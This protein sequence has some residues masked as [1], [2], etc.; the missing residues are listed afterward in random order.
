MAKSNT[1]PIPKLELNSKGIF[2][3]KD[4][5][6]IKVAARLQ[7]VAIGTVHSDGTRV[8]R[9]VFQDLDGNERFETVNLSWLT[10]GDGRDLIIRLGD[11]GYIWPRDGAVRSLIL[12]TLARELPKRRFERIGAPGWYD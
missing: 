5:E 10:T 4:E 11:A 1:T 9:L 7:V 6:Q 12:D 3:W 8:A 2:V